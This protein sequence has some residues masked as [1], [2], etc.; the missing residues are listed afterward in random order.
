[1]ES[2]GLPTLIAFGFLALSAVVL[3]IF[4]SRLFKNKSDKDKL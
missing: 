3:F 2:V 1:M 4:K